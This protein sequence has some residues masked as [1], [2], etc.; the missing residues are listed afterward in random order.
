MKNKKQMKKQLLT[1][2]M[3][4]FA[5][6]SAKAQCNEIFISEY[7]EG[8]ANNK[9]IELYNPSA[10]AIALNNNYRMVRYANGSDAAS[11]ESNPQ[12]VIN[13]G[14]H[15]MQPHST[16]VIVLDQRDPLGTGTNIPVDLGLQAL[17]D[18]FLCPDF[19]INAVMY[20]NGNDA[21]SLQKTTDGGTTW[22][23]IDILGMMG[24]IA[25][26]SS[27]SWSDQFPYDGSVGFWWT[28]NHT[29]I[30]KSS[31]TTGVTVNPS[32]EFIVT[33]EWDSLPNNTWS[34]LH[35]HVCNC[36]NSF[37]QVSYAVVNCNNA[38]SITVTG[39][40]FGTG[41]YQYSIDG[42]VTYQSSTL[43]SGLSTGLYHLVVM[44]ANNV[45][46]FVQN[47][48]ITSPPA[49]YLNAYS[50][51]TTCGTSTGSASA[52]VSGGTSPYSYLWSNG[53]SL[54]Y[55]QN[56]P[57]GNYSLTVTDNN[58]CTA[59]SPTLTVS[60]DPLFAYVPLCMVSVDS[61]SNHNVVVWE[62]TGLTVAVD[63]FKIYREV[64]TNVYSNI[65]SVAYDSLSEFHDYG[66]NPNVTSYKY[67]IAVL[68]SCGSIS[69][70][71]LYHNTIHLQ[72][73]G[74]GNLLWSLYGIENA[75]NPVNFYIISRDDTGTGNFLPIS[76]TIPGGNNS[77]TDIN[78][79]SYPN[80]RYRV[81]V[82]W[83]ISCNPTRTATTTHSNVIHLGASVSVS[84]LEQNNAVSISPNPF[85]NSTTIT[86]ANEQKNIIIKIT[87]VL[88]KEIK[89]TNFSGK[90]YILEKRELNAGIYFISV[91]SEQGIVNRKI[92]I[93]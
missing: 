4:A 40:T 71:S 49:L 17:A 89:L 45:L 88:G 90:Q 36:G 8:T 53:D 61:L 91:N 68:D 13:L 18:T 34:N 66:A 59:T 1:I 51:N 47:I 7:V 14:T 85:T 67:K 74:N 31:V 29:L 50:G 15:V 28:V 79:A 77:Y 33:A 56:L 22:N 70:M 86:F 81:D 12:K 39:V 84:E 23:Y 63:S 21:M 87:D 83:N 54:Y 48:V 9:A 82:T 58:G 92:I 19:A 72:Y 25:M 43:F 44:D 69:P 27:Q 2:I 24:D 46:S 26:A 78:Y 5:S 75:A 76:S 73:L 35:T 20:F 52:Y 93:Q 42:G 38:G 3:L 57:A 10:S 30:R 32:P 6:L 37:N 64:T 80:A 65:G 41:P 11:A 60:V 16:W 62:K 55:T